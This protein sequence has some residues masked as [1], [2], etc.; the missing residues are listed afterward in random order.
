MDIWLDKMY[1][2]LVGGEIY[3]AWEKEYSY[4]YIE[5]VYNISELC[6]TF[7]LEFTDDLLAQR[8]G[9][10]FMYYGVNNFRQIDL[11]KKFGRI[12]NSIK[13]IKIFADGKSTQIPTGKIKKIKFVMDAKNL[14]INNIDSIPEIRKNVN[15]KV[16][17]YNIIKGIGKSGLY[18]LELIKEYEEIIER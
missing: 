2:S 10:P 9:K 11:E 15:V 13:S 3:T 14:E 5:P 6:L 4:V 1:S 7:Y 17:E 18:G 16:F 12:W 8:N